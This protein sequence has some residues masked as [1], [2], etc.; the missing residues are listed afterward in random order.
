MEK[1][2]FCSFFTYEAAEALEV[3][4]KPN[5]CRSLRS[6]IYFWVHVFGIENCFLTQM[7]PSKRSK[8]EH[9]YDDHI[10]TGQRFRC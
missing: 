8:R 5:F 9:D 7:K 3:R 4:D 2:R 10:M 1:V 6:R